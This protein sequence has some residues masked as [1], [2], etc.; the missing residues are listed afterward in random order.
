MLAVFHSDDIIYNCEL[1]IR[2][3]EVSFQQRDMP[4]VAIA[5]LQT[6]DLELPANATP[7]HILND[8][9]CHVYSPMNT[10]R[11]SYNIIP[12]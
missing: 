3:A 12:V 8:T 5:R 2:K 4:G 7:R 11:G 9:M 1:P 6:A 10:G